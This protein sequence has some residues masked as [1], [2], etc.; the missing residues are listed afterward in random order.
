MGTQK[1]HAPALALRAMVGAAAGSLL[2]AVAPPPVA[3]QGFEFSID[4]GLETRF[5]PEAPQFPGQLDDVQLSLFA[6]ADLSWESADRQ[7]R[8]QFTPFLRWDGADDERTHGDIR[9]LYYQYTNDRF[10]ALF[11]VNRVFWGVT[12]SRHLVNIINQIDAVEDTDEEDFLGQPMINLGYQADFGRFDLFVLPYHR[13]RTF[14]GSDGRFRGALPVDPNDVTYE[15]PDGENAIDYALRY[16]HSFG[17]VDLGLHYFDGTSREPLLRPNASGTAL[18]QFYQDISQVGLDLQVT[19]DATL[20]KLEAIRRKGQ[21]SDFDAFVA[22]LEHT[23]FQIGGSDADLGVL[24]EYL[25]DGR[26][27]EE[28]PITIFDDDIFFGAR[29]AANDISDTSLLAG[30]FVD[31]NDG[32][33]ALR[34]EFERRLNDNLF[35][36]VEGQVFLDVD[37]A[38]TAAAFMDDSQITL[39]LTSFF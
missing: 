4:L 5:F 21:G 30:A 26:D 1:H 34:I 25:N 19:T 16:S 8:F 11:G 6:E 24:F 14:P 9:E 22:G 36:E 12:E 39:R 20:W 7:H 3:A 32:S 29:Y 2:L 10:D 18:S 27:P 38:N 23:F 15:D 17:A 31:L 33:S 13:E 37:P 28:A 35:F